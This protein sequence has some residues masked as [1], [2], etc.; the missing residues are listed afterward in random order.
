[1]MLLYIAFVIVATLVVDIELSNISDLIAEELSSSFGILF[2]IIIAI[3]YTIS[4]FL[5][6]RYSKMAIE[7][8]A[9]RNRYLL[10]ATKAVTYGQYLLILLF[11]VIILQIIFLQRY[12]SP[13]LILVIATSNGLCI[14]S[15]AVLAQRLLSYFKWEKDLIVLT[16]GI[17]AII[18]TITALV[19]VMFMGGVLVSKPISIY[20][21]SETAF[22]SFD[23]NSVTGILNYSYYI[24]AIVSFISIWFGTLL[25]MNQYSRHMRNRRSILLVTALIL[26]FYLSQVI[27]IYLSPY[28]IFNRSDATSFLFYYRVTFAVSSTIGG[29]LFGIPF[30]QIAQ[31]FRGSPSVRKYAIISASGLI[32]FFVSGSATVYHTP[33]PPFGIATVSLIGLSSYLVLL[34]IYSLAISV[35]EDERVRRFT[36]KTAKEFKFLHS[37]GMAEQG[38]EIEKRITKFKDD[39]V[40]DTGIESSLNEED[41]KEYLN[42]VLEEV[43]KK[44]M[45]SE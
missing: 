7:T 35:S 34:G 45:E 11:A 33:Y 8:T 18:V 5:I 4:Q 26:G 29:I 2:F 44:K 24:F 19:T 32:L 12:N 15:M 39:I 36:I 38:H 22:S 30:I 3:V 13:I 25:L 41:M 10:W 17:S 43:Q 31:K 16:Y 9:A 1:M 23:P 14:F 28:F 37:M 20:A 27:I 21:D 6:L 42:K 40:E